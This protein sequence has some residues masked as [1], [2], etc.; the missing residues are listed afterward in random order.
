[1]LLG[2]AFGDRE[3]EPVT[4]VVGRGRARRGLCGLVERN[5]LFLEVGGRL[6]LW[7]GE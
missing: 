2:G 6:G 5:Q 4:G 3:A 1:M 7:W